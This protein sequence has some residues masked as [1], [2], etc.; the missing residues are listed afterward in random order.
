MN[1]IINPIVLCCKI[2]PI[3]NVLWPFS[4]RKLW[5]VNKFF[6]IINKVTSKCFV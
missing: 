5:V 2:N 4:T 3:H 6:R 1:G